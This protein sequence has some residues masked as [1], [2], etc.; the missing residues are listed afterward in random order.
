MSNAAAADVIL[1]LLANSASD[2]NKG[3]RR[4]RSSRQSSD[5][6]ISEGEMSGNSDDQED[7]DEDEDD[8]GPVDEYDADYFRDA[9]DRADLM[10][11]AEVEREQILFERAKKRTVLLDHRQVAKRLKRQEEANRSTRK[12]SG[13]ANR[14]SA[15]RSTR[16][17][18]T[19]TGNTKALA[20]LKKAQ[21]RKRARRSHSPEPKRGR[22]GSEDYS[23]KSDSPSSED[24]ADYDSEPEVKKSTKS[25]TR[26]PA[27]LDE[28]NSI[29]LGRDRLSKWCHSPFFKDTVIGCFVRLSL[30]LDRNRIHIFRIAEVVAVNKQQKVYTIGEGAT[31]NLNLTLRHG[32]AEKNFTMDFVSN[33]LFTDDEFRR[34]EIQLRSDKVDIPT[35]DHVERKRKDIEHA[36]AYVLNSTEVQEILELKKQLKQGRLNPI[37]HRTILEQMKMEHTNTEDNFEIDLQLQALKESELAQKDKRADKLDVWAALNERNRTLNRSTGREAEGRF[38]QE[39]KL[40]GAG[41]NDID[42]FA[43]RKTIPRLIYEDISA[44]DIGNG[45]AKA[46]AE[47]VA[48]AAESTIISTPTTQSVFDTPAMPKPRLEE[49]I[50]ANKDEFDLD[51]DLSD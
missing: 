15:R 12:G 44:Q 47:A 1:R 42:P 26:K 51:L 13:S 29:R 48:I 4:R 25:I 49:M 27:T 45:K 9:Q 36:K 17:K 14:D 24:E 19:K 34:F 20:D 39:K 11:M 35:S 46:S 50:A 31:T 6:E 22:K 2:S 28:L 3:R 33:G 8:E 41:K 7:D 5:E 37:V 18:D 21:E 43:R 10:A 30:G 32:N 40:K 16:A 38:A 23:D